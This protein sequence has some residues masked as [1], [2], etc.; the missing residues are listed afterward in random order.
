MWG[1]SHKRNKHIFK[2]P[3]HVAQHQRSSMQKDRT[4]KTLEMIGWTSSLAKPHMNPLTPFY[5]TMVC[6]TIPSTLLNFEIKNWTNSKMQ[7]NNAP[8]P[9]YPLIK[10][11][12]SLF[13]ANISITCEQTMIGTSCYLSNWNMWYSRMEMNLALL[14][15]ELGIYFTK[16][17]LK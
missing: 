5:T 15:E 13:I 12:Y 10:F 6:A 14:C 11:A 3:Q 4:K 8:S 16:S 1:R 17:K 2:I 7:N 9:C